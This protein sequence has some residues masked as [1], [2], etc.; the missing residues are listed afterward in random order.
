MKT[1]C[2]H[3]RNVSISNNE[4]STYTNTDCNRFIYTVAQIPPETSHSEI[5]E[6]DI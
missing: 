4:R 5:R 1:G 2:S 3:L 6:P